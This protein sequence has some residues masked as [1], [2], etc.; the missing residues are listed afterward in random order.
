MYII[1]VLEQIVAMMGRIQQIV[2]NVIQLISNLMSCSQRTY[3][4]ILFLK[5]HNILSV[6]VIKYKISMIHPN[7]KYPNITGL[8]DRLMKQMCINKVLDAYIG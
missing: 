4:I 1:T 2:P 3:L 7:Y 5:L 6:A 8:I